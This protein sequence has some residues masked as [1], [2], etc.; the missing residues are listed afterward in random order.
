M[1]TILVGFLAALA[2]LSSWLDKQ[3]FDTQQWG[4]TSLEM[5]QNPEIQKQVAV[6]AVDELYANV[7]VE[8]EVED[9]LPTDLKPLSGVAAGGLRSFADQG[10]QKAL[11]VQAVQDLWRQ[12]NESAHRTLIAIIED[13]STVVSTTD[14]EVELQLRPLIIEVA[15]QV[16]LGDQARKNIPENVGQ[17][18]I[19]DSQ[20]LSQVQT[21]AKLIRGTAL[22]SAL[23]LLL[24]L[25]LAVYLSKG[26]R[27][28][29]I[30]WMAAALIIGAVVVLI[31]RSVAAGV[32]VPE[33]GTVELQP[34]V[35]AAYDI[36]TELLRSIAWT[37]IWSALLLV[38]I[39]WL[40]SPSGSAEKT[41]SY[42]AVPLGRYP[43]AALGLLGVVA[44]IFLLMGATDQQEFLVRLMIV[45]MAGLGTFFFR[46]ALL[47]AYPDANADGLKD[48]GERA[49]AKGHDLWAKRPKS[50]PR[51]RDRGGK[52][53][54]PVIPDSGKA[55]PKATPAVDAS[56]ETA[57]MPSAADPETV[58]MDQLDRLADMHG[59]GVLTDE[60]FASEKRRIMGDGA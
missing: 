2:I 27:W 9:I 48:F 36:T 10:A 55:T 47:V 34:A 57:T 60:E 20:Q 4:E 44:F 25:G 45:V 14:G 38:L 24:L 15:D 56:A 28:L 22:I 18:E 31:L 43:G 37:V 32:L 30:L 8:A 7:D 21:A 23:L 26:Y 13:D 11:Q 39:A 35:Q 33:L 42:L 29:T 40:V 17:I 16:G 41:R 50:L 59:R 1:L 6:Y 58:R 3:I 46:R 54:T 53:P 49:R 19:V 51:L 12:A 52:S 5:L